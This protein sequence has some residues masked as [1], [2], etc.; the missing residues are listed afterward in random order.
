MKYQLRG[1]FIGFICTVLIL[2]LLDL[3]TH[4]PEMYQI[5]WK[6]HPNSDIRSS[7]AIGNIYVNIIAATCAGAV[8]SFAHNIWRLF[9][10][11]VIE[12]ISRKEEL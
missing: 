3:I 11:F 2:T 5:T 9:N 8:I 12:I 7:A 6:P 4:N 1:F 10:E